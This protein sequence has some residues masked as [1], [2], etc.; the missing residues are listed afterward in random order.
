MSN[1]AEKAYLETEVSQ[2][3]PVALVCLLHRAALSA[4][5]KARIHLRQK[6]IGARSRQIT[7]AMETL[8]ELVVALDHERGGELARRLIELYDYMGRRLQEANFHQ[9]EPPLVEVE[10]LLG[11]LLEGWDGCRPAVGVDA[12]TGAAETQVTEP[13]A[14]AAGSVHS[15]T[16]VAD[17]CLRA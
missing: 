17:R 6:E 13:A 1:Y 15:V 7:R 9:T 12:R 3:D 5:G 4:V 10:R 11:T 2:A 14:A 16:R 8:A